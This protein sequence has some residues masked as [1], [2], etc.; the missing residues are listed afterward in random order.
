MSGHAQAAVPSQPPYI[1]RQQHSASHPFPDTCELEATLSE[2]QHNSHR[3]ELTTRTSTAIAVS[4]D[5]P[6]KLHDS[7]HSDMLTVTFETP[8]SPITISITYIPPR[9]N[10][11]NYIDLHTLL[12]RQNGYNYAYTKGKQT[13]SLI[14]KNKCIHIGPN[15]PTLLTHNSITSPDIVLTNTQ[16]FQNIRLQPG[17]L[18]PSDHTPIRATITANPIQIPIPPRPSFHNADWT[19]YKSLLTAQ[20][21]PQDPQPTLEETDNHLSN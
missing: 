18:T 11:I 9:T 3:F 2:T 6:F 20:T 1:M 10:Y 5:F 15:F 21:V 17:P 16:T 12:R 8:Q 4:K 14:H 19:Q 7:F 13:H